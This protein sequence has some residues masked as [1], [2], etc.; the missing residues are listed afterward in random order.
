MA[1]ALIQRWDDESTNDNENVKVSIADKEEGY[2]VSVHIMKKCNDIDNILSGYFEKPEDIQLL[3]DN[4]IGPDEIIVQLEG[5][6]LQSQVARTVN[7]C[8]EYEAVFQVPVA[9]KHRLKVLRLRKDFT[10]VRYDDKFPAMTYEILLDEEIDDP[11]KVKAPKACSSNFPRN[12]GFWVSEKSNLLDNSDTL[13]IND[14]C[15]KSYEHRGLKIRNNVVLSNDIFEDHCATDI[16]S[17]N[18]SRSICAD[19]SNY[20]PDNDYL[21]ESVDSREGYRLDFTDLNLDFKNKKILF[22]GDSHMRGLAT[23][24]MYHVCEH[25][26]KGLLEKDK[27]TTED[28][29]TLSRITVD[30][31]SEHYVQFVK[32]SLLPKDNRNVKENNHKKKVCKQMTEEKRDCSTCSEDPDH[33]DCSLYHHRC[34]NLE[35]GFMEAMYCEPGAVPEFSSYDY[36]IM[37]CGHHPASRSHYTYSAFKNRV[38]TFFTAIIEEEKTNSDAADLIWVENVA[39]PLHQDEGT[40]SFRDWRTYH[41]IMLFGTIAEG[42]IRSMK[43][44]IKI[45]PSFES[46]LAGFDKFCDCGHYPSNARVPI[47]RDLLDKL[48]EYRRR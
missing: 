35:F 4:S 17:Y 45:V 36:V 1:T 28:G 30:D 32:M 5:N 19:K 2:F 9:G 14:Q 46:T 23:T 15:S 39:P 40:R 34:D 6:T 13:Y 11:L 31:K 12:S 22:V 3:K 48:Q 44:P 47:L 26:V 42:L 43:V 38:K 29:K 33:M 7:F 21:G 10:A 24:F 20:D 18:W 8:N 25:N 16:K 37:N 41:R 27:M